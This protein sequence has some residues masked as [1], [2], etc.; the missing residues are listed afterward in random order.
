MATVSF[1]EAAQ[2]TN[3]VTRTAVRVEDWLA[4][5]GVTEEFDVRVSGRTIYGI[6]AR[7]EASCLGEVPEGMEPLLVHDCD[8]WCGWYLADPA[9]ARS[10]VEALGVVLSGKS[11]VRMLLGGK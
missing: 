2:Y 10:A 6:N 1:S 3:T 11:L 8:Q 7:G 5:N 9:T 4:D